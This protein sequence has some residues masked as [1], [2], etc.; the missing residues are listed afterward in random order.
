M[1]LPQKYKDDD[2]LKVVHRYELEDLIEFSKTVKVLFVDNKSGL[3]DDYFGIFKIFFHEIDVASDG[4]E[5]F[6]YFQDN[7][8]DLIITAIDMPIMDGLELI[9]K[10]R[11]ISRHI[12]VLVLSSQQKYFIDFIRLGID[13]YI[14]N[15]I[16]VEQFVMIIQKVIEALQNKQ[17]LFEYRLELEE[18]VKQKTQK[19]QALND[20]LEKEVKKEVAKRVEFEKHAH[21]KSKL[22]AMGEMLENIAHQWRQPLSII[23]TS[24]TGMKLQKKMGILKDSEFL[25]QCDNIHSNAKYLSQTIDDFRNFIKGDTEIVCFDIKKSVEDFLKLVQS[26]ITNEHIDIHLDIKDEIYI[27]GYP[28]ELI[29]CFLNLFNNAKDAFI[30]N[31][32]SKN[33]RLLFISVTLSND[34]III[35]FQDNARGVPPHIIDKIFEPYFTTKHQYHGTGL[36]LHMSYNLI[37]HGMKGSI[38]VENKTFSFDGKQQTGALFRISIPNSTQI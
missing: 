29:Q 22:A 5:A 24:A 37:V 30:S 12:T 11:Q 3:R 28:N 20:S 26:T 14:L 7:R 27:N 21:N 18:K 33:E 19:L 23:S 6:E 35:T 4:K 34:T 10:V 1:K 25:K 8:Y 9:A 16:E 13:G 31:H 2:F 38:S 32:V 36:G 17:A 15:P